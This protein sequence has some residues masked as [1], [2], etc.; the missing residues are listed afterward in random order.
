MD[1]SAPQTIYL[2]DYTPP[3]FLID[4]VSLD[5]N[6]HPTATRVRS[7]LQVRPNPKAEVPA[8][9]LVLDGEALG[10]DE[11]RLN[12]RK[13]QPPDYEQS[14]TALTLPHAPDGAFELEITT[15]CN[16]EANTVLSGLYRSRNIFCTQ[17]EAQGFRR[18]TYFTDRPD[19][20]S[21]YTTRLQADFDI[22]P[23]LLANGNLVQKRAPDNT[24]THFAVWDDPHPKPSYLFAMVGGALDHVRDSFTTQSGRN[25]DLLIY[26]EPGSIDRCAWAMESLKRSMKWDEERFGREYDLDIFMIVA[27]SDFNMGAMENKGLNIFNDKLILAR[28]ETATDADYAAIEAVIAHEYF[29][30]WTGNRITCRDWFQLC[31]KEGLTVYRDQEFTSDLRSRPV[32]RINDVRMLKTHQF[33]EDGGPLAHPVRPDS[34]IEINN[35]YTATVYEKGAELCRMIEA[36]VGRDGF[37]AGMD[38]YFDRHDGDAATVED[39]IACMSEATGDDLT[40]FMRWYNQ[41]GT[42][43]V[44]ASLSYDAASK[45]AELDVNQLTP[46]TPGQSKKLPLHI[47]LKLGLLGQNGDDLPL[48]LESGQI[49]DD[50][51][52]HVTEPRQKFRF[53][54]IPSPPVASL[55]REFSAPVKLTSNLSERD[56]EFLMANDSDAFN[57]WQASQS[58]ALRVLTAATDNIRNGTDP[59]PAS[60]FAAALA[61]GLRDETLEAAYRAEILKMPSEADIARDIGSDVDPTAIHQARNWLRR[62]IAQYMYDELVELY[63]ANEVS[64]PYSPEVSDTGRRALRNAALGMLSATGEERDANRVNAHYKSAVNMTDAIAALSIFSHMDGEKRDAAFDDFYEK[65]K[66]D[67]LV[68]DKWFALQAMSTLPD[69]PERVRSLTEHPLFSLKNPNKVRALIGAF[70]NMN[71]TGF[72]R[73]D[74]AGFRLVADTVLEIDG[75]NPQVSARML[76]AFKT[77]RMLEASRQNLAKA[78][79]ERI[80]SHQKLSRDLYEIVTK[81]LE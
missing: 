78:E 76:G 67:H 12:G 69:V 14:D 36:I 41:S 72:C 80:A 5:V 40:Q 48:K 73:A 25:V 62:E 65:W 31:L 4:T 51:L 23:V 52:I 64:G 46:K 29:H 55:L 43:E 71:P 2:K 58:Y 19:V 81:T 47:P 22:A 3:E 42:P 61:A 9:S 50:G 79:L 70:A 56:L 57:R 44:V 34:Y 1:K 6:L 33:P 10:L 24:G 68:I 74:G 16:P 77:W 75:I 8:P 37:R 17:C 7:R 15:Y 59:V 13:L 60:T 26:V 39:F 49:I 38:L 11:V 27:V 66:D 20:L 28:P 53:T 35:F 30:N 21:R 54:D 32:E 18:I 63:E 45:V